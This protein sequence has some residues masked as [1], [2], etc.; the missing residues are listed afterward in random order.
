MQDHKNYQIQIYDRKKLPGCRISLA[1]CHLSGTGCQ[2]AQENL[3][4]CLSKITRNPCRQQVISPSMSR[5]ATDQERIS[6]A[7]GVW[8]NI[9]RKQRGK[10]ND[11]CRPLSSINISSQYVEN[12]EFDACQTFESDCERALM[13]ICEL[14]CSCSIMRA[15]L[16]EKRPDQVESNREVG[17]NKPIENI[18]HPHMPSVILRRARM[19]ALSRYD[20]NEGLSIR[21][22]IKISAWVRTCFRMSLSDD[23]LHKENEKKAG[24]V[25][26]AESHYVSYCPVGALI[27]E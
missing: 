15:P 1:D 26:C 19:P 7:K 6:G 24:N 23:C 22:S 4:A 27:F 25:I 12:G 14:S 16:T 10:K 9:F 17:L 18:D 5:S 2:A 21:L 11:N 20:S 8:E 3:R 13:P